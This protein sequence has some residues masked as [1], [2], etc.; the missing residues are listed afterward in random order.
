MKKLK[1]MVTGY[2]RNISGMGRLG[3]EKRIVN[4]GMRKLGRWSC[5]KWKHMEVSFI[6]G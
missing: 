1:E 3:R 2:A 5:R 4:I 6:T